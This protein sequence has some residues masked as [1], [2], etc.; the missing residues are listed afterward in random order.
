MDLVEPAEAACVETY[1]SMIAWHS[2]ENK[3][4]VRTADAASAV[5]YRAPHMTQHLP[6]W[7]IDVASNQTLEYVISAKSIRIFQP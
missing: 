6:F 3:R 1:G 4:A 2:G 5:Y 7:K